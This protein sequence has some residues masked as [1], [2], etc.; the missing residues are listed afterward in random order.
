MNGYKIVADEPC[1][2]KAAIAAHNNGTL[3][4]SWWHSTRDW[5]KNQGWP[6]PLFGFKKIFIRKMLE[7]EENFHKAVISSGID[8]YVPIDMYDS[9]QNKFV[10]SS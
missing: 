3:K 5:A 7:N 9:D 4:I 6:T 10:V 1:G 2:R 8:V